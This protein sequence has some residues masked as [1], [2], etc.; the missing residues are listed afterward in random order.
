[1]LSEFKEEYVTW[2]FANLACTSSASV[3]DFKHDSKQQKYYF[4][5]ITSAFNRA[6]NDSTKSDIIVAFGSF[7]VVAEVMQSEL[8]K[9]IIFDYDMIS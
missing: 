8:M 3:Y 4:K 7:Y 2:Y 9:K 1:M 5:D 6:Y